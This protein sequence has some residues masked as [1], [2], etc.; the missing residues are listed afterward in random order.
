MIKELEEFNPKPRLFSYLWCS[1]EV[2]L[3]LQCQSHDDVLFLLC[4]PSEIN[5]LKNT[6][7]N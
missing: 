6:K 5:L 2:F 3:Q 1:E 7:G 4:L